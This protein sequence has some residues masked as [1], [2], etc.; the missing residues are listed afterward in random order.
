MPDFFLF[1]FEWDS[2]RA[3]ASFCWHHRKQKA[4][5]FSSQAPNQTVR[6]NCYTRLKDSIW[7]VP[8]DLYSSRLLSDDH[9]AHV[10]VCKHFEKGCRGAYCCMCICVLYKEK[11]RKGAKDTYLAFSIT[12]NTH[13][14]L[15]ENFQIHTS[16]YNHTGKLV[17]K[18]WNLKM[19]KFAQKHMNPAFWYMW[20]LVECC[21]SFLL[22]LLHLLRSLDGI[23][24]KSAIPMITLWETGR[25]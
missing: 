4:A 13:V 9:N 18:Y 11:K 14:L 24:F 10:Y 21:N 22:P 6:A 17:T 3:K 16:S 7:R 5:F 1:F 2:A 12:A 25:T 8:C 19:E 20:L 23:V 15:G